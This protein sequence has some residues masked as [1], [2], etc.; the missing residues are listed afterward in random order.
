MLALSL[1]WIVL[2]GLIGSLALAGQLRLAKPERYGWAILVL[3]GALAGLAGGWLGTLIYGRFFGTATAA[4]VAVAAVVLIP[5]TLN[6]R[7]S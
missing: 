3:L 4:W 5:W 1:L 6:R 7:R 2:G